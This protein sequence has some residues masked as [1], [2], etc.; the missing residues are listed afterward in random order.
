MPN[1]IP[2][3][4]LGNLPDKRKKGVCR[5]CGRSYRTVK[6]GKKNNT[7]FYMCPHCGIPLNRGAILEV[8][9]ASELE[10]L[11]EVLRDEINAHVEEAKRS[12]FEWRETLSTEKQKKLSD[13]ENERF[14]LRQE[15]N[16]LH[17]EIILIITDPSLFLR[18]SHLVLSRT[19]ATFEARDVRELEFVKLSAAQIRG[20]IEKYKDLAIKRNNSRKMAIIVP[21]LVLGLIVGT[22]IW[23]LFPQGPTANDIIPIIQVPLPVLL[24]SIIG[25]VIAIPYRFNK[26]VDMEMRDPLRWVFTRPLT[27]IVMGILAYYIFRLGLITIAADI[28][29]PINTGSL[30]FGLIAFMGG[31]SDRFADSFLTLLIGR[32]GGDT[33]L[34]IVSLDDIA[35][36]DEDYL[37]KTLE[38]LSDLY[39][40]D[41]IPSD[42]ENEMKE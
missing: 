11:R 21:V 20:A 34:E 9:V 31:F 39:K 42:N 3:K 27:G 33:T 38:G 23:G 18:F 14:K 10:T 40:D 28:D 13:L 4:G 25:S 32:F 22:I 24:W 30:I 26:T 16:L 5:N 1:E 15:L 12:Y 19:A 29:N 17:G 7:F 37:R 8:S 36:P 2:G 35:I 6:V 41:P